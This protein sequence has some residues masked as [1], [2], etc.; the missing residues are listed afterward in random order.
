MQ[1]PKALKLLF[2]I[3]PISGGK[4]KHDWEASIREYFKNR[5]HT[6]EIFLLS[7]KDDKM[8]IQYHI[9]SAKPDRVVAVGGDGTVKLLAEILKET[10][11]PLGI[12]PAGSANGMA[13]E[14]DIP[15]KLEEALHVITDGL[16]HKID[17]IRINEE[18]LCIHLSDIGL[19]AM[20]VKYFETSKKR[21]MWGYGK[22]IFRVMWEKQKMKVTIK[23]DD[24][25]VKTNA[26]MV[27][28]ANARK[29]GTG[30]NINPDGNVAD[31]KF[32]VVVVRK[33]NVL[34]ICKAIFTNKSF[35]GEKIEVFSTKNL[36][37]Q[38]HKKAYFQIDG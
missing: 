11:I 14:L 22:A 36:E 10:S 3:N 16:T 26:Y 9:N 33:L 23:T 24:Q 17:L 30:A 5:I 18:E 25:V 32:E 7:G 2:V 37:L 28:F 13:K 4:E 19:N 15:A 34:E 1:N 20:L 12:I 31:G 21:G 35:D 38:I 8:S 6:I 27:T 29:Y